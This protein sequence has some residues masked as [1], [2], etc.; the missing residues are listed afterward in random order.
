MQEV[1]RRAQPRPFE[2]RRPPGADPLQETQLGV[3]ARAGG[4]GR[5]FTHHGPAQAKLTAR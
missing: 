5:L 2:R 4:D 1:V 3:E